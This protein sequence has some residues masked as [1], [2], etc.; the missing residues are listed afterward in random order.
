M[1]ENNAATRYGAMYRPV[2]D[3]TRDRITRFM[4]ERQLSWNAAV[5]TLVLMGLD[6]DG[7]RTGGTK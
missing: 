3:K 5:N 4:T 2:T 7:R 6:Q 1:A